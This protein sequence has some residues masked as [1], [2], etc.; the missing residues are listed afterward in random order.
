MDWR[1]LEP[2]PG[3]INFA[4]LDVIVDALDA[5][6]LNTLFNVT[7]SPTWA[8]TSPDENGPPDDLTDFQAFVAAL[9]QR[10]T[11]RVDAYEIWDEPNLR[12]NWNCERRMCDTDYLEML[13]LAYS[14]IK[15]ADA[16][17]IVLSAGLAPT[18]FN[19][20]IN[21]ID[22]RLYLATLYD[23]GLADVSD[24]V[25]VHPGGWANPP[26]ARCCDQPT[27]V[28]THFESDTFY[29]LENLTAYRDIMVRWGDASAPMWVTKFGW[30]SSEDTDPPGEIN[31]FVTYTSLAEQALYV[32]R[33]FEIGQELDY[34]G[35]MFLDNLNGCQGLPTR[36]EV[37]YAALVSP[38]GSPR[39]VFDAVQ[40][41]DKT[42]T[43]G[44]TVEGTSPIEAVPMAT[45]E[46]EL[47]EPQTTEEAGTQG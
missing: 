16:D 4:D 35:P 23:N 14:A 22:D 9:A 37:C 11:G 47:P 31:V 15:L 39:L 26:D 29:F 6:D 1:A 45:T 42:N 18:R 19:D 36:V 2:E 43:E 32:P 10:Y 7:N 30:G 8:R 17:A 25:G 20:R 5:N 24:A 38:S 27:G 33:A 46:P 34:V 3:N 21:A 13:T 12:R 44:S 40:A 41:I 28:E